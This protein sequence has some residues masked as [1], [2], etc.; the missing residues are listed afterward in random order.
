MILHELSFSGQAMTAAQ[1]A[2]AIDS[3][4]SEPKRH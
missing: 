2:R 1:I 4:P 3:F